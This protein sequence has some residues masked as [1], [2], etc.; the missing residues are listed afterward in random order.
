MLSKLFFATCITYEHKQGA[1]D[2]HA[3]K[4]LHQDFGNSFAGIDT[5]R[6]AYSMPFWRRMR[7]QKIENI[8]ASYPQA[9]KISH[10]HY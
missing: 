6:R 5:V 1:S 10:N 4:P 8:I 3:F 9:M 7:S 2:P